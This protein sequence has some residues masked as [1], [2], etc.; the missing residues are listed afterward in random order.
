MEEEQVA[1]SQ[2]VLVERA[3]VDYFLTLAMS[4]ST[5]IRRGCADSEIRAEIAVWSRHLPGRSRDMAVSARSWR[6]AVL[7]VRLDP[8]EGHEQAGRRPV[9]VVSL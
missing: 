3:L 1:P 7:W 6:W 5:P 4:E 8:V 2:D 9:L